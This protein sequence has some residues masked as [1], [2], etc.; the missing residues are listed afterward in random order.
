MNVSFIYIEPNII[1]RASKPVRF[2]GSSLVDL[3]A[4]PENARRSCGFQLGKVQ[5]GE[6]P[7]DWKPMPIVGPG[8]CEIRVHDDSGAYRL[9]Y[10]AKLA[11]AIHVLHA[12]TKKSQKTSG[13][14]LRLAMKRYKEILRAI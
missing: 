9:I 1:G 7:D 13:A 6:E 5:R 2:A 8:V 11:S 14:D 4:F 12:F 10:V 3:R